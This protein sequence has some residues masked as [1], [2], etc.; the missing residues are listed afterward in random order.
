MQPPGFSNTVGAHSPPHQGLRCPSLPHP[1]RDGDHG[2]CTEMLQVFFPQTPLSWWEISLQLLEAVGSH[3]QL[4]PCPSEDTDLFGPIPHLFSLVD[5]PLTILAQPE[6]L[7]RTTELPSG[8]LSWESRWMEG[9]TPFSLL[10]YYRAHRSASKGR[11]KLRVKPVEVLEKLHHWFYCWLLTAPETPAM[12]SAC[13]TF[14][15]L[16]FKL[17]FAWSCCP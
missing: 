6:S 11:E 15:M 13:T 17:L 10:S 8:D 12:L 1:L 5:W 3:G 16:H 4:D 2:L 14:W 7:T 9:S